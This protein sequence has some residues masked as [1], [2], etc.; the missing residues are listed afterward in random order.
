M[1]NLNPGIRRSVAWLRDN[2]FVTIDS[3]DGETHDFPCDQPIPFVACQVD[4]LLL[5]VE[6]DRLAALLATK[7]IPVVPFAENEDE[8]DPDTVTI[9]ASYD[10]ADGIAVI[11]ASRLHDRL[12]GG[13][14]R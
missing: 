12:L 11:Q 13:G 1:E 7:Q 10:P 14:G 2:G 6:A 3:G 9:S 5:S 4:P 8:D